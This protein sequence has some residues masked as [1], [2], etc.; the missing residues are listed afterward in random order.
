MLGRSIFGVLVASALLSSCGAIPYRTARNESVCPD[1]QAEGAGAHNPC[2]Q[3]LMSAGPPAA[4][5]VP[6][7]R[8]E[9]KAA[10]QDLPSAF[11]GL[12]IS[13]GGSRAANFGA[14]ALEQLDRVGLLRHVTA[15][16]TTSGGGLPGAFFALRGPQVDWREFQERMGADFLSMW[17]LRNLRPDKLFTTAFTHEDRS[18]L[19]ADIFDEELFGGATY[20]ALGAIGPGKPIFLANATNTARGSRFTF[21][22]SE[23]ASNLR[24]R[25]DTYPISQA[26]I[27]SAAFPG[28]FNS[29]SLRRHP[30]MVQ[31]ER[32]G[33]S[34]R[35]PAPVGFDH[36]IDG[37]PADNLGVESLVAL[38]ASHQ[39]ARSASLPTGASQAPC[40]IFV[41]DAYPEGVLGRKMWE[42]DPRGALGHLIDPNF[43]D[44]FDALLVQ[45]RANLLGLLGLSGPAG[46]PASG[47]GSGVGDFEQRVSFDGLPALS[48]GPRAQMVEVDI[49]RDPYRASWL[50]IRRAERCRLGD[51]PPGTQPGTAPPPAPEFFRC[52]AWHIN[53]SGLMG[54]RSFVGEPGGQP[55]RIPNDEEGL[56]HP[57]LI[58]RGRLHYLTSQIGTNF[59][60]E[61]PSGCTREVLQDS[62]Y[63]AAF[64][65]VS[66]DHATRTQ[67]C[68]WFSRAGLEVPDQCTEFP[69]NRTMRV[70]LKLRSAGPVISDRA[71]DSAVACVKE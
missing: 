32:P 46:I 54:I 36:L 44:A 58:S 10:D 62:L 51:C 57:I 47:A 45:R 21:S 63:A 39:L 48:I 52:T 2:V 17:A 4:M 64:I 3:S 37:G 25:L 7:A 69:G 67:A 15:I 29:V 23:F 30:F 16:S 11:V 12:S 33:V 20:G 28:V 42:P 61:G 40:F 66:E 34:P 70:P 68:E 43:A 59:R 38:A 26:V 19:M 60:L 22:E 13:G 31:P 9:F 27:A 71:G 18:D 53:L 41:I 49:P 8:A 65:A 55:R 14:A 5:R 50:P 35:L 24:S 6:R 56:R 1:R